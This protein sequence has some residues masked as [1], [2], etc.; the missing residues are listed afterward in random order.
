MY[1][2]DIIQNLLGVQSYQLERIYTWLRPYEYF[3]EG[4]FQLAN[5]LQ[6][7]GSGG[8]QGQGYGQ[9]SIYIP[10]NH[11]D[12]IF[13]IIG[14]EFGFIGSTIVI[15]ILFVLMLHL[16]RIASA[17][18]DSFSAYFIVGYISMLMFQVFQNIGMTIQLLPITGI[19]LPFLSYGGTALWS[20]MLAIGI[21]L[22][23]QFYRMRYKTAI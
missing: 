14:E 17:S 19:P 18:M 4:G 8:L 21:V 2:P 12:F 6:A 13:T 11:T 16:A 1:R 22:S 10:E 5:S 15:M 7:I 3:R 20:N 23:I 9:G